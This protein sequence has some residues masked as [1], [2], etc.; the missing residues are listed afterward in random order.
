M[1]DPPAEHRWAEPG[2]VAEPAAEGSSMEV[3]QWEALASVMREEV[4]T[5]AAAAA[6]GLAWGKMVLCIFGRFL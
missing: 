5:V 6:S 2:P 3:Q 1:F 4:V